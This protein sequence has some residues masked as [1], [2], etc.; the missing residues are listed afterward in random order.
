MATWREGRRKGEKEGESKNK[1]VKEG[2]RG[3]QAV[4]FIMDWGYLAVAR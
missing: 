1:R 4:P 2:V 3:G